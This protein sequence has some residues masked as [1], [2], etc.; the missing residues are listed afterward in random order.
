M[1][2]RGLPT[3]TYMMRS[4][5]FSR[6]SCQRGSYGNAKEASIGSTPPPPHRFRLVSCARRNS[7]GLHVP[8]VQ[9]LGLL[10]GE[11]RPPLRVGRGGARTRLPGPDTGRPHLYISIINTSGRLFVL[12]FFFILALCLLLL[13][14]FD[15]L[16]VAL[17]VHERRL[18]RCRWGFRHRSGSLSRFRRQ[19]HH[20]THG[21]RG[22]PH[23]T[24]GGRS[25]GAIG[26]R[27]RFLLLLGGAVR[28][29]MLLR[30]IAFSKF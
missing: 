8:S 23:S 29:S 20:V 11:R 4:P 16:A 19:H 1:V 28:I 13:L 2:V 15:V 30:R 10:R 5:V 3:L 22:S 27:E 26:P 7:L 17:L 21:P 18:R 9:L 12:I 6:V 14:F 24:S 25:I